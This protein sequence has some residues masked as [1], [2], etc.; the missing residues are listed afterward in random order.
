MNQE[1]QLHNDVLKVI[2]KAAI[3]R[4]VTVEDVLSTTRKQEVIT[5]R[6]IS[7]YVSRNVFE[8]STKKLARIYGYNNHTA[9]LWACRQVS[10]WMA[11][12]AKVRKMVSELEEE[13]LYAAMELP[14]R[15]KR[16]ICLN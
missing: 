13:T 7:I 9:I 15:F 6:F 8:Y 10:G 5:A 11:T 14:A 4:G 3:L 2:R 1:L 12:S 16:E